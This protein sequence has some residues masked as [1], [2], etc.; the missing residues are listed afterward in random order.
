MSAASTIRHRLSVLLSEQK[1]GR[2][3]IFCEDTLI[4]LRRRLRANGIQKERCKESYAAPSFRE[5]DADAA[6]A[7][8][9]A[10]SDRKD[11]TFIDR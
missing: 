9:K 3:S 1:R 5:L 10:R 7:E 2:I 11:A 6:R 8:L 4:F